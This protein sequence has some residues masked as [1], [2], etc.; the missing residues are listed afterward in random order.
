MWIPI[1][2]LPFGSGTQ[3]SASSK[4]LA[5]GGSIEKIQC[6]LWKKKNYMFNSICLDYIYESK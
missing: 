6:F 5:V 2:K 4:S 3:E 1:S